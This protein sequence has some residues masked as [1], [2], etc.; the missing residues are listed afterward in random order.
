VPGR[1][2]RW[3][4]IGPS[5][6]DAAERVMGIL[7]RGGFDTRT[8]SMASGALINYASGF[9]LFES[10]SADA[11]TESTAGESTAEAEA[12]M[13]YFRALPA[14]RYPN[15]LAVASVSISA[16]EQFEYGLQRLLDGFEMDLASDERRA[17][18]DGGRTTGTN[19]L[20]IR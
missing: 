11:D 13:A 20:L 18:V 1:Q 8:T 7:R 3:P 17:D 9:A 4:T 2:Q 14:D 5:A 6:L 12:V 10:R 19:T 16:D 15:L